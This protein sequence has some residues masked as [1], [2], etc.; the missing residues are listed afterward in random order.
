MKQETIITFEP[1]DDVEPEF[2]CHSYKL[3]S[4]EDSG[5]DTPEGSA[6]CVACPL[7]QNDEL[8]GPITRACELARGYCG[9]LGYHY[10]EA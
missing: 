8:E 6:S 5:I 3:T 7:R 4:L 1:G 10:T 9:E 2:A